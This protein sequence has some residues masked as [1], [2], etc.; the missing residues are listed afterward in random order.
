MTPEPRKNPRSV[1]ARRLRE[2]FVDP[3][4]DTPG[5]GA[6]G[7]LGFL[8]AAVSGTGD[9]TPPE[10]AGPSPDRFRWRLLALAAL[11]VVVAVTVL[12]GLLT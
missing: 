6:A 8:L 2:T 10:G 3:I 5:R 12:A 11:A 7:V 1:G 9:D 4:R